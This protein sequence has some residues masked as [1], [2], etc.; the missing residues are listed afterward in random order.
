MNRTMNHTLPAVITATL[1]LALSVPP[2]RSLIEQ[3]M[4]W[5]M[6]VQ[7]PLLVLTGAL[8]A[9][10]T[11]ARFALPRLSSFNQFG[12]TAFMAA[13]GIIA[14]WMLPLAIDRAV[15]N[16]GVDVLKLL[17]LFVSGVLLR[18][19]FQRAPVALQLFFMGYWVSMMAW[20]GIYFA[21]TDL[22]LC[23]AYSQASQVATGWSLLALGLGFGLF[24]VANAWR[25][26]SL[27]A[28][29]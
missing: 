4:A 10:A 5:H 8:A 15:V 23:N 17:T 2:L 20:L 3:S 9:S 11:P 1:A 6:V 28:I 12:L 27:G 7:M 29:E 26:A 24:W 13:Q 18:S 19:A 14:Y 21:S 25:M 16:P 22:R